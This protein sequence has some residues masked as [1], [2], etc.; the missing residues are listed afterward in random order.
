MDFTKRPSDSECFDFLR[1]YVAKAPDGNILK[2]LQTQ[3]IAIVEFIRQVP[4]TQLDVVHPP[5]GWS[6]RT[7]IEHCIDAERI[8]AYRM[9][10]FSTGDTTPLPGWDEN[11]FAQCGYARAV[12]RE[13][14]ADEILHLR[15]SNVLLFQRFDDAAWDRIGIA[16]DLNVSVRAMAWGIAGHWVHHMAILEKRLSNA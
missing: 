5:Y 16:A 7:V 4:Q 14:L 6:V 1:G 10:R 12:S 3:M 13:M 2:T 8:W 11:Q 15:S 9:L